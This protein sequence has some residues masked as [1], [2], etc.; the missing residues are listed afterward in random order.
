MAQTRAM[1]PA[2]RRLNA[3]WEWIELSPF[4][5]GRTNSFNGGCARLFLDTYELWPLLYPPAH[6]A[7][8]G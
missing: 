6:D 2:P 5:A 1:T 3:R 7:T 8:Q 4:S